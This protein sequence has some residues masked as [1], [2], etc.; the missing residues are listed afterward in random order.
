M[1]GAW[2]WIL[3]YVLA[4]ALFQLLLYR[5]L[6][7][8]ERPP[9]E[10]A[11]PDYGDTERARPRTAVAGVETDDGEMIRCPRCGTYNERDPAYTYCKEC[12]QRLQ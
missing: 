2:V 10:Q 7:G 6:Q 9:F 5:Y 11:T 1:P 3:V 4:F 12:V 8:Q